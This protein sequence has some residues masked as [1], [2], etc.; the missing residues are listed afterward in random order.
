M[1]TRPAAV[2][3][4]S[5]AVRPGEQAD[6]V[7]LARMLVRAYMD[8]P[9]A[10]WMCAAHELRASMLERLYSVRLEEMLHHGGVWTDA[11]RACAAVWV[12]PGCRPSAIRANARMLGHA[13]DPRLLARLHLLVVGRRRMAR[14]HPRTPRHWYL[15]LLGTDPDARGRGLAS[16]VLQPVLGRCDGA[17]LGAYLESSKP[18]NLDFYARFGFQVIGELQLPRGPTLWR[19][20]REPHASG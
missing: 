18:G 15:S 5:R 13:L 1:A 12:P 11:E 17:E 10:A 8:D 3:G 16:S 6:V 14:R 7:V 2:S 19:M 9:V 20:W 4:H